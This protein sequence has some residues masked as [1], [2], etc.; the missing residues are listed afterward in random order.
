MHHHP[1]SKGMLYSEPNL[2][3]GTNSGGFAANKMHQTI[4]LHSFIFG[5]PWLRQD[6]LGIHY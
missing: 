6:G 4:M 3:T 1:I 5:D 2:V